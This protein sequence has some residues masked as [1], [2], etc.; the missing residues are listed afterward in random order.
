MSIRNSYSRSETYSCDSFRQVCVVLEAKR[1][2]LRA[3]LLKNSFWRLFFLSLLAIIF[4]LIVV[5]GILRASV[6]V[7]LNNMSQRV[8]SRFLARPLFVR[9]SSTVRVLYTRDTS[10]NSRL[11]LL[12]QTAS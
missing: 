10:N 11:Q 2:G 3:Y 12:A 5:F 8:V 1:M 6:L 7:G 9:Q 4:A